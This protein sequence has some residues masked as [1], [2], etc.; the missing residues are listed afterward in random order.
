MI[1]VLNTKL[2]SLDFTDDEIRRANRILSQ[3]AR[4]VENAFSGFDTEWGAKPTTND[5]RN[6][7]NE[8]YVQA[9]K[10]QVIISGIIFKFEIKLSN[11]FAKRFTKPQVSFTIGGYRTDKFVNITPIVGNE[12]ANAAKIAQRL[13]KEITSI[14]EEY[15]E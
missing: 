11:Y 7:D 10:L 6:L 4:V 12:I 8:L 15:G 5:Y 13:Q 14:L 1:K 9:F 3:I 2:E